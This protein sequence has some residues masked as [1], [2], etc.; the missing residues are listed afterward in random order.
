[1]RR[2]VRWPNL[3]LTLC[4]ALIVVLLAGVTGQAT[5]TGTSTLAEN[6]TTIETKGARTTYRGCA[7]AGER[8]NATATAQAFFS[9]HAFEFGADH[10]AGGVAGATAQERA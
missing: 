3:A 8:A 10:K 6:C 2:T 9:A 4:A 1:M 7:F 5:A